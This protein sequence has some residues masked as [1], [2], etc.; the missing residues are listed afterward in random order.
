MTTTERIHPFSNGC[1]FGDW[2]DANCCRCVRY[3]DCDICRALT[4]AMCGDGTVSAEIARRMGYF[5]R[6][7]AYNW[8]CGEVEWTEAWK[9]EW[10]AIEALR[11]EGSYLEPGE[12]WDWRRRIEDA[13]YRALEY[14]L[15]CGDCGGPVRVLFAAGREIS[16]EA[17]CI[18]RDG[19]CVQ[20]RVEAD[21][22]NDWA[23]AQDV[24]IPEEVAAVHE[25]GWR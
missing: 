20:R 24:E 15:R 5:A 18:C 6:E 2:D 3:D 12:W 21:P 17:D 9:A 8:P 23:A 19:A 22:G 4:E 14:H 1:Q 11:A 25:G 10:T 7:G 13:Y 16:E